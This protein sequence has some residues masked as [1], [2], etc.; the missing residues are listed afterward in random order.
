MSYHILAFASIPQSRSP[1]R[2][3]ESNRARDISEFHSLT[4][5]ILF[6]PHNVDT[7]YNRALST[8]SD[9]SSV[10]L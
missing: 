1:N 10:A 5:L 6:T 9:K 4:V 3:E 8:V 2:S 7:D